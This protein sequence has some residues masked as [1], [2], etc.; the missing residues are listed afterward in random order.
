MLNA[1]FQITRHQNKSFDFKNLSSYRV[2]RKINDMTYEL[3]LLKTMIDVFSIFHSWLLHLDDDISLREQKASKFESIKSKKNLWEINEIMRFKINKR[4]NDFETKTREKCFRYLIR[5]IDHEND[6]IT[7]RWLDYTKIKSCSHVVAN[8]HHKN[9]NDDESHVFFVISQ[10]W[11]S[12]KWDKV[13][14]QRCWVW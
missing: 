12:S 7:S 4:K 6:N 13:E 14:I 3:K 5:W 9:L 10:D 1:R 2:I 8:F 11:T